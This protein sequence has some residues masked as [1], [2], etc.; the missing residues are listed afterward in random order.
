MLEV[1]A[2]YNALTP[3]YHLVYRDWEASIGQQGRALASLLAREW[4][5]AAQH[6]IDA[7]VGIG[8]QA[9]GLTALGFQVTCSDVSLAAVQRAIAES[10]RRGLRLR[11]MIGDVRALPVRSG[12]FD[13]VLACD[14]ALPHLL[15][16]ADIRRAFREC[17]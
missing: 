9:I 16:E 10:G 12:T 3:W 15:S 6:V 14:N 11:C 2:F 13:V 4:S 7:A 17:L 5:S 8:T 1:D